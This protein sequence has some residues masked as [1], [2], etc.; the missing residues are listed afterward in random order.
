MDIGELAATLFGLERG[1]AEAKT[2]TFPPVL[3]LDLANG[4]VAMTFYNFKATWALANN[5]EGHRVC[6]QTVAFLLK[7]GGWYCNGPL[8]LD[9]YTETRDGGVLDDWNFLTLG[10]RDQ[11]FVNKN[12]V[13]S[14]TVEPNIF[15]LIE[16]AQLIW[17]PATFW[18]C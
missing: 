2:I 10:P 5:R 3:P 18:K 11:C 13:F 14:E 7:A 6:Y 16:K 17:P 12:F 9:L 15:N 4:Q 1:Q 8:T